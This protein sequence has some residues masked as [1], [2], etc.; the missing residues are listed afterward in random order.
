MLSF[1][2]YF[3]SSAE[4]ATLLASIPTG[5]I[6]CAEEFGKSGHLLMGGGRGN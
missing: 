4:F 3:V 5:Q 6:Y 2:K 1:P